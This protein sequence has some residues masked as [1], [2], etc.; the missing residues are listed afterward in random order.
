MKKIII[1]FF[2]ITSILTAGFTQATASGTSK[3][4][5]LIYEESNENINPWLAIFRSGFNSKGIS[6]DEKTAAEISGNISSSY[7]LICI[8]G[9]VMAFTAKEPVRDWL[10]T[11]PDLSERKVLLFVTANRWFLDK[12]TGQLQTLLEAGNADIVDTVSS[13]TKDLTD[14]EKDMIVNRQIEQI[15]KL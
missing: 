9:A 11:G 3:K 5:L 1:L 15:I 7:D 6:V 13:A 14:E 2:L 8:Y 10:E 12:Y 4:V